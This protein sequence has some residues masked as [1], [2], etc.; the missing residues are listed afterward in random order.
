VQLLTDCEAY[1]SK[2]IHEYNRMIDRAEGLIK[3]H[4]VLSPTGTP[5]LESITEEKPQREG[6]V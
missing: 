6:E 5:R 1:L 4:G 3:S 2:Y